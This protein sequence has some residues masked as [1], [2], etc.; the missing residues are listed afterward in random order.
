MI[1]VT[2]A[3]GYYSW[4]FGIEKLHI[5]SQQQLDQF[6]SH[7][8]A[9][10]AR[11]QFIPQ[12]I[13]KNMLL[14]D[15]LKQ[16]DS[17]PR[18]DIVNHFLED[19]NTI[20]GASDTYLMNSDGLTLAASNWQKEQ[21]FNNQNFSFRPYFIEA[22]QGKTGR[23]FALGSTSG[24]RGYYFAYPIIYATH[25][26]GVIVVKMDLSNIELNWSNRKIQFIVSDP[27]GITFITTQ[28]KWLYQS[29]KPLST[30]T[31][32]K[33]HDSQRY[34]GVK[35][36]NMDINELRSVSSQSSI[37]KI[38]DNAVNRNKEYFAIQKNMPYAGW[39]VMILA[40]L[41]ELR[42]KQ[43]NTSIVIL[44]ILIVSLLV[45]FLVWQRLKRRQEREHF[46]QEAQKQ[47]EHQVAVRTTDLTH[48]IDERKRT[49]KTLRETQDELIQTAKLAVLGQ[50]SASI[51]HE[52]NN[53]LAAI[54]SYTDNARKFLSM[55]KFTQ[56]DE[57]LCR[58]VQLTKRMSKISSQLKFF[59]RK[60]N[61]MMEIVSIQHVIKSAIDIVSHR[62]K[63]SSSVISIQNNLPDLKVRADIIQLEQILINLI[64]NAMQA[65]E[66][67]NQ[68]K[69]II[70]IQ[71]K[72][73]CALIHV[74]DN[75]L[76][77]ELKH[78]EKIF[79]P[80]FTT[81]KT[82]LGLGLSISA[83]IMDIMKGKLSVCNLPSGGA[84]FTISLLIAE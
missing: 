1:I 4:K 20:I 75:G 31:L 72:N 83:R 29:I 15:L 73:Q 53:P 48:E 79:D 76:G 2:W 37:L 6:V 81:K 74:D 82:G 16:P 50:M 51:S 44:L 38:N 8:D 36:K 67:K 60:S 24:K 17:S 39:D 55:N 9:R 14:V 70:H 58:I 78:I 42:K 46:Q 13:S 25:H 77:I 7:L 41:S 33:I 64:N 23:Y 26:L 10:L 54:H 56:V 21:T 27:Q 63:N 34:N 28:P 22:M 80:F 18:I 49:E 47:L 52:L 59:S 30:E 61:Q 5:N 11:F 35:I 12:L 71:Q 40:P 45:S 19:I 66:D 32:K 62:Y 3:G 84:R 68:G 43:F 69:V 57:N 65:I